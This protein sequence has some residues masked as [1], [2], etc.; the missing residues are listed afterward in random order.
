MHARGDVEHAYATPSLRAEERCGTLGNG[1]ICDLEEKKCWIKLFL[2]SLCTRSV[3]TA[4]WN[5][6][7]HMNG[8]TDPYYVSGSG[9]ISV[10]LLSVKGP[11]TLRFHPKYLILC[12]EDER[13]SYRLGTTLWW[14][15]TERIYIFGW[16]VPLKVISNEKYWL[17][18][19]LLSAFVGCIFH[20]V[21]ESWNNFLD[22][23][24]VAVS[25]NIKVFTADSLLNNGLS[26]SNVG[27]M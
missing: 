5:N 27:I 19:R 3:L 26:P 25:F 10:V 14:V 12:L 23:N 21:V 16:T 24:P 11:R 8:F 13:R 20:G 6:R 15:I 9:N 1:G 4:S 18:V 22:C 7:C 17:L 2:F